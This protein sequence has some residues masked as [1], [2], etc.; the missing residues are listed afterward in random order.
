MTI[1]TKGR[2]F[3]LEVDETFSDITKVSIMIQVPLKRLDE[4]KEAFGEED[5]VEVNL[6]FI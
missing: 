5:G 1:K 4:I 2:I 3:A 6:D